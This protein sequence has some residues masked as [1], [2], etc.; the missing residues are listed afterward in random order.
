MTQSTVIIFGTYTLWE[1]SNWKIGSPPS[2]VRTT[3]LPC[4]KLHNDFIHVHFYA[5]F[6]KSRSVT[7]VVIIVIFCRNNF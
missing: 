1:I 3:V 6:Q 5:L 4:K 2:T 7:L